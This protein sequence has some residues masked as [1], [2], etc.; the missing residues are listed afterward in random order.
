V[1]YGEEVIEYLKN[2]L[3]QKIIIYRGLLGCT[4]G[5]CCKALGE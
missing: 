3:N 2:D 1:S 4:H 5:N